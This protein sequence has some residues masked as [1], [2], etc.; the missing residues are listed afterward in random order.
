M[1]E[2]EQQTLEP[3]LRNCSFLTVQETIH[4]SALAVNNHLTDT[5]ITLENPGEPWKGLENLPQQHR[6]EQLSH[7]CL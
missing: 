6:S 2:A 7:I 5:W 3:E 4:V 1:S